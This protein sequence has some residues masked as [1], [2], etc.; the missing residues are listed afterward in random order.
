MNLGSVSLQGNIGDPDI[1]VAYKWFRLAADLGDEQ[2]MGVLPEL[3]AQMSP[4]QIAQGQKMVRE[5]T[6]K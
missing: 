5:W 1:V 2:A 3:E 6:P 4:A